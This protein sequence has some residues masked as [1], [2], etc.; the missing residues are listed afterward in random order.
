MIDK[1]FPAWGLRPP[2]AEW[3]WVKI[4]RAGEPVWALDSDHR[5]CYE[6]V[7][8]A[9]APSISPAVLTACPCASALMGCDERVIVSR[10]RA[11][12]V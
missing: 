10:A 12:L 7:S 3:Y 1:L 9:P 11:R 4:T 5:R 6:G 2:F 8:L